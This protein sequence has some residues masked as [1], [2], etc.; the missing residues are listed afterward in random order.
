MSTNRWFEVASDNPEFSLNHYRLV[1]LRSSGQNLTGRL[2]QMAVNLREQTNHF[3]FALRF[4]Y[5]S[6][7][8]SAAQIGLDS[9]SALVNA[10]RDDECSRRSFRNSARRSV[11]R[12]PSTF[13]PMSVSES[14]HSGAAP[15]NESRFEYSTIGLSSLK[16]KSISILVGFARIFRA[17]TQRITATRIESQSSRVNAS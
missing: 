17:K 4:S 16:S 3:L 13:L 6:S 5:R 2:N 10:G 14:S 8:I 12:Q 11:S 7:R 9:N 1:L 15:Q